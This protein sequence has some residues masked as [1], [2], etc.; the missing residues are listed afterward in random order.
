MVLVIPPDVVCTYLGN[1]LADKL[2]AAR[3]NY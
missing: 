1:E 2:D 3:K